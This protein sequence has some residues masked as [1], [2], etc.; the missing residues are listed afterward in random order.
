LIRYIVGIN[1]YAQ[2]LQII[3]D[4]L[5]TLKLQRYA[6]MDLPTGTI[7]ALP[8]RNGLRATHCAPS[9]TVSFVYQI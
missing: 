8:G 2:Q 1:Q 3:P 4:D 5:P 6:R 7:V 9:F